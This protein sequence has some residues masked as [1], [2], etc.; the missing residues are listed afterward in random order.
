MVIFNI[1]YIDDCSYYSYRL[2]T[3][4]PLAQ[5]TESVEFLSGIWPHNIYVQYVVA[6]GLLASSVPR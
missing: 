5:F 1:Y 6:A 2:L 4:L 3:S